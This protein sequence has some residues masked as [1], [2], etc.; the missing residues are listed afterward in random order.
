MF[1]KT[2]NQHDLAS[3]GE[4]LTQLV[5]LYADET[6]MSNVTKAYSGLT[7]DSLRA[8]TALVESGHAQARSSSNIKLQHEKSIRKQFCGCFLV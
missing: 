1:A 3:Q 2:D 4:I 7:V 5:A 6:L 8:A